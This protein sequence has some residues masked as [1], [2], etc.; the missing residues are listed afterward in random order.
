MNE[1]S[2]T[3]LL[4]IAAV[5]RETGVSKDTLRVWERRYGFPQPGR[6]AHGERVYPADQVARLHRIRRL[7][8]QG[9][10]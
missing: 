4:S 1:P 3:E 9:L 6:N 8:D 2:D 10:R 5:E 7:M